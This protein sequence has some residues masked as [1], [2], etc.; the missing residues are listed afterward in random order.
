MGQPQAIVRALENQAQNAPESA[1]AIQ[2]GQV[3]RVDLLAAGISIV[4]PPPIGAPAGTPDSKPQAF[5]DVRVVNTSG[6]C[7]YTFVTPGSSVPLPGGGE[8]FTLETVH[9]PEALRA[10]QNA[11]HAIEA[12]LASIDPQITALRGQPHMRALLL[13]LEARRSYLAA[14]RES[15][16]KQFPPPWIP[17]EVFNTS[18]GQ[19]MPYQP[20]QQARRNAR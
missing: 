19:L 9:D 10:A 3:V 15:I 7:G 1:A 13:G 18:T 6:T 20:G 17:Q 8:S 4:R 16:F 5:A 11:Y 12:E 2:P 14:A